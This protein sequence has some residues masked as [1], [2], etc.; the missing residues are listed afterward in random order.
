MDDPKSF[1]K[2]T[3]DALKAKYVRSMENVCTETGEVPALLVANSS[4]FCNKMI[5]FIDSYSILYDQ[6][7]ESARDINEKS[8]SLATTMCEM[9]RH[10]EQLSELNRM[11]RCSE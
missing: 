3:T 9:Q 7:I 11:T 2:R 4:V 10:M 1:K 8:Q 6:V 5:D